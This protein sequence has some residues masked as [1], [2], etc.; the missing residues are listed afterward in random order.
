MKLKKVSGYWMV[1]DRIGT[2]GVK[3]AWGWNQIIDAL[4][5]AGEIRSDEDVIG[6]EIDYNGM[7]LT[8]EKRA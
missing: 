8:F 4:H 5:S 7:T 3:S 2:S 6:I 1:D